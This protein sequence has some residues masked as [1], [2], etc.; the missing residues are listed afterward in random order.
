MAINMDNLE[1]GR[2]LWTWFN[3][4]PSVAK[5]IMS[6]FVMITAPA[7][8][9][10]VTELRN[11]K[12]V[13]N[14]EF[15]KTVLL[16]MVDLQNQISNLADGHNKINH[17]TDSI[18]KAIKNMAKAQDSMKTVVKNLAIVTV[19]NSNDRLFLRIVPYLDRIEDNTYMT[20]IQMQKQEILN[21]L[22]SVSI[23]ARK[24]KR[25]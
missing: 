16:Y 12:V 7:I 14:A 13:T 19:A 22:D 3:R 11:P 4:L 18:A 6:L 1:A 23:E 10:I 17:T 21:R 20:I 25:K 24:I 9:I 8:F 2:G 15:E 5:T